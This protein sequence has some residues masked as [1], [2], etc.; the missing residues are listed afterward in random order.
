MLP[1]IALLALIALPQTADPTL[2]PAN[3]HVKV[4]VVGLGVQIYKCAAA[5]DAP[6]NFQ[7]T[8][9]SPVA[10][11]FD[12]ATHQPVGTHS[13]G[14]TWTWKD[15]SAV[16]GK[17]LQKRSSD[18]A[19]SVPWLLLETHAVGSTTGELTGVTLVRRS[20]TQAGAAPTTG[21]DATHQN[22]MLRVPYQATYT[23]YT[24]SE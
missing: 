15:G 19:G 6:A 22:I 21:C 11:L 12:P 7:W 16:E 10:T 24:T 9:D 5:A 18:E 17:V 23:F 20:D 14:P 3:A 1:S 4:S 13:A 2:P 8:L